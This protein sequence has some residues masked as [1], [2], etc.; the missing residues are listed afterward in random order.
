MK[1]FVRI[2][3]NILFLIVVGLCIPVSVSAAAGEVELS[4][5]GSTLWTDVRDVIVVGEY[6]YCVLPY[7]LVIFDISEPSVPS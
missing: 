5:A 1:T 6:A 3:S 2:F 4:Y 7:G